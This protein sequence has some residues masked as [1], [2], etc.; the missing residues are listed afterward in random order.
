MRARTNHNPAQ[1]R[2]FRPL[3]I[4]QHN[5]IDLWI[6]G[7][8]DGEVAALVG[9]TRETVQRWRTH[10][11]QVMAE[12]EIRRARLWG[13]TGERLRGLMGKA[14][15]NIAAAIE[16]GNLPASWELL[17]CTSMYGGVV[18]VLGEQNPQT[19]LTQQAQAQ[20]EQ[21]G[22]IKDTMRGLIDLSDNPAYINRV[23]EIETELW[24][25]YGA[26]PE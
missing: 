11:P 13:T 18:N 14:V 19:I 3:T 8:T 20:A 1:K 4:Q 24:V 9:V 10:W 17:K 15:D 22:F 5:A 7:K 6:V 21:E 2:T 16:A 12:I 23:E 26:A 25:A